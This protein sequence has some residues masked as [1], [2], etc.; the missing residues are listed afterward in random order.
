M[1]KQLKK[2]PSQFE[3]ELNYNLMNKS[4]DRP[5]VEYIIDAWKSLEVVDSIKF[6]SYDYTEE[7]ADIDI[8]KYIY[9]RTK[10]KKKKERCDYKFI[11]D[12]RY[13]L[14]TVHL[15][16]TLNE[17]N[18]ETGEIFTHVY[19]IK[20]DMLVPLQDEDG[21]F[22]I[23][24][25]KY[26]LIYQLV[27]KSTY[28]SAQSVTLKSLM[29]VTVKR[30]TVNIEDADEN[31]YTLP[32]YSTFVFKK[33]TPI[34]LFYLSKGL[35]VGLNELQVSQAIHFIP[36]LPLKEDRNPN[37]LYFELSS[38]VVLVVNKEIFNENTYIQ[39]IVGG[40]KHIT[41]N[42][43]KF[44]DLDNPSTWI[45]RIPGTI[46]NE[47]KGH[48]ILNFF[49]RL[50]DETTKKILK[51]HGFHRADIYSLM[52]WMMQEFNELRLKDNMALENKRLR[53]NEYIASLLTREF[54]RRLNKIISLGKK[55]TIDQFRD[56]FK[57]PG[58]ILLQKMHSS[59]VL[60]FDD[61]V[62]DMSFF[63]HFKFTTKG[64]NSLGANNANNIGIRYRDIHPSFLG[65]IDILVCG[66]SDPGT[67]GTLSPFAEMESLY[68]NNDNEPD[69]WYYK[70]CKR[71]QEIYEKE[72]VNYIQIDFDS[73][74]DF[75]NT[76]EEM[77]KMG[78]E[79]EIHGTSREGKLEIVVEKDTSDDKNKDENK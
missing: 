56:L 51:I 46:P 1:L 55:A 48:Q 32:Y 17:V 29:P 45:R 8:N 33:E 61:S 79:C 2:Y 42:R 24:G 78:N 65:K 15:E 50:L 58:D 44:E 49:D 69:D 26:Y 71:M 59:G 52:R 63:S 66:N 31:A 54:S 21:Y 23:K 39:S 75:Y 64:P 76:L 25:K 68:F 22:Y 5:L 4:F 16:V 13:G 53:C 77:R 35:Y 74:T 12:D 6:I 40:F 41:T 47:E 20:K 10:K 14:L 7:E 38:S 72:N 18:R 9:K 11:H 70:F 73:A 19:P 27:E 62:N 36:A 30:N 67:S 43:F 28:T 3:D 34:L 37:D 57:F 60:R